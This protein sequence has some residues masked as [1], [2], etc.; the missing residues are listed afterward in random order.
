MHI[1][2]IMTKTAAAL[3]SAALAGLFT[4]AGYYSERLPD[5]VTSSFGDEL[6][7]AQ[8]PEIKLCSGTVCG[9]STATLSLFGAIPVK[10]IE[11]R[12]EE[13]PVFI[14]GGSPF[15]IKLLMEGVMVT[16]L[17]DVETAGGCAVCPAADAGLKTGDIVCSANGKTL[18]SNLQLQAIITRSSGSPIPLSVQRD[19]DSFDTVLN[20]VF[21]DKTQR[22]TGGMWVRDSI[23]GI[24]TMTFIDKSTGRFAGLGHPIC[25][26]DT[27][28][29]VPLHSGE[30]VPV[31][32]TD[33]KRG[34]RGIPGELHGRFSPGGSFGTLDTNTECGI[35]GQ[36]SDAALGRFAA[37][38]EEFRLG[39]RQDINT[40]K[41]QV[42]TTVNGDKPQK[43]DI[44]IEKIDYNSEDESKNMMITITDPKLLEASGGIVQGMSG[45]PI[46][47]NGRLI[48]AVTHVFV[49]D[50]SRGFAIF[51][52]NMAEH[53]NDGEYAGESE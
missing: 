35:F 24:G 20:P 13:A 37:E 26:S 2:K 29:M 3:L 8:Y 15:G 21:S 53:M 4:A 1:R 40:G 5:S 48:G 17:G 43:Y 22:W 47:Q 25:D 31:D 33:T 39:Y 23:A 36:L 45:S 52:E 12:Q 38:G 34:G 27:G 46:I 28:G 7:I 18:T 41:A 44:L 42:Y 49:S 50:P 51:A 16:G 10:N 9:G 14:A 19:G 32:I 11:V 6:K 30:A